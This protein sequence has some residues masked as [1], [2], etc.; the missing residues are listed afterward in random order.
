MVTLFR[1]ISYLEGVS[2]VLLL[3]ATAIKYFLSN[4]YWVKVLGMPHGILFLIYVFIASFL[5]LKFNWKRKKLAII[6]FASVVPLGTIYVDFKY[7]N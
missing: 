2:Y 4:E 3:F 6:L 1:L 5:G 7:F